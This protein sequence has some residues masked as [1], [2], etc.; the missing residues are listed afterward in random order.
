MQGLEA[1][2]DSLQ[3]VWGYVFL[4]ISAF[5]ENIFPPLPGDMFVVL[6][7][8]L[9]SRGQLY[10]VPAYLAATT[11]SVTGFMLLFWI[12]RRWGRKLFFKRSDKIFSEAHLDQIEKM[13]DRYGYKVV[14][15]NRFLSGF[16]SV[17]SLGAGIANMDPIKVLVLSLLSC[18]LWNG[19]IMGM[20]VWIGENWALILRHYQTAVFIIIFLVICF[21][22]GRKLLKARLLSEAESRSLQLPAT[23]CR[24]PAAGYDSVIRSSRTAYRTASLLEWRP[25]LSRM[26]RM[27]FFTVFS[28]MKSNVP[29]WRLVWP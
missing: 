29:I 1:F 21:F 2:F 28:E 24:L 6:G 8:F 16:R 17:V 23:S 7:A 27:W 4:L 3:G 9:V 14:V 10:F 26:L 12:G 11:G 5:I 18:F 15:F 19:L 20:G 13:M 22:W 25:S